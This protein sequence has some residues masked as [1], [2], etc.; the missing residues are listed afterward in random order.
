MRKI[1]L[2]LLICVICMTA[3]VAHIAHK[4][5]WNKNVAIRV[6]E[7]ENSYRISAAYDRNRTEDIQNYI[8]AKLK[9]N[10]IFRNAKIDADII[11]DDHTDIYVKCSPGRLL[12]KLDK[13]KNDPEAYARIKSLGE[14]IK[15]KLAQ[16]E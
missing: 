11:L 14:G 2:V 12:I 10:H 7:S 6:N 3:F 8:D 1:F 9:S 4:I 13:N 5:F 15:Q 16:N